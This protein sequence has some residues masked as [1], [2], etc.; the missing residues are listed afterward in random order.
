MCDLHTK[1]FALELETSPKQ[2]ELAGA[3]R[4]ATLATP[5]IQRTARAAY[6]RHRGLEGLASS[7]SAWILTTC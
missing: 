6:T 1:G 2:K 5:T 4:S 7:Y 3:P